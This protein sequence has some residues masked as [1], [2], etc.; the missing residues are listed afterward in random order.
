MK[1]LHLT[2]RLAKI[3]GGRE[4][5]TD[6]LP[7]DLAGQT[8][9][10][11]MTG[12]IGQMTTAIRLSTTAVDRGDGSAAKITQLQNLGQ[13]AGALLFEGGEGLRRGIS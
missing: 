2:L 1:C 9:V 10:G 8:E 7:V 11:A 6:G 12:L 4:A 13:Y 3:R 5:L